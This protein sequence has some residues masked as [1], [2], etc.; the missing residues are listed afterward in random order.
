MNDWM[1]ARYAWEEGFLARL[2]D[3]GLRNDRICGF[4]EFLQRGE[5]EVRF[6]EG[7]RGIG[8]DAAIGLIE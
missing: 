2:N 7:E 8:I 4:G 1:R 6:A 3:V 5:D